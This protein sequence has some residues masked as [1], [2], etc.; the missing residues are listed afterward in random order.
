[1]P[2]SV[3]IFFNQRYLVEFNARLEGKDRFGCARR[4]VTIKGL[5]P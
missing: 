4:T 2:D 5:Y 1:M 3:Y